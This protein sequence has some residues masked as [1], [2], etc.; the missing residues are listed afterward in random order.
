[1]IRFEY[2]YISTRPQK[3]V[4]H[5][6][7]GIAELE[8]NM[9]KSL[10]S[11]ITFH[12]K[13]IKHVFLYN[14]ITYIDNISYCHKQKS[15][16]Q[17]SHENCYPRRFSQLPPLFPFL[18]DSST[19]ELPNSGGHDR[20]S[21]GSKTQSRTLVN[22]IWVNYNISLTWNK[23]IWGWFLL[24]TMIPVRSQWARYNLP[25]SHLWLSPNNIQNY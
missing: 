22:P 11:Y 25:R 12:V 20:Q 4:Q 8:K 23:A 14:L 3:F 24:L 17:K 2:P 15:S 1:M 5:T 13:Q 7:G 19:A 10:A 16:K 6:A 9:L 18:G 21:W